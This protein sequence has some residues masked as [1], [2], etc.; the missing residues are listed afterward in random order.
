[1][2]SIE[3]R[4]SPRVLLARLLPAL[5]VASL[6][7]TALAD[8][9]RLKTEVAYPNLKFDRPVAMDYPDDGSDLLFVVEQFKATIQSFPDE[10][11]TT[12]QREFLKLPDPI[13]TENEEGLLGLAFHPKYK[14]NGEFFVY[15]S[16]HDM[17]NGRH[18]RRAVVSRVNVSKDD[19]RK[20]DPASEKRIWVSADDPAWNHNGG[21]I[22]FGPDGFLYIS[23][24]DGGAADDTIFTTGQNPKDWFGSILR[25]DVDHP[26]DGKAYG[27]P[28]DNPRLRDSKFAD[29]APEVYCIGLRNVWKFTFDRKDGTLW[30][31]D[32]GQNKWEMVHIIQNGGNYGWSVKESFHNFNTR[33][34][35]N[36]SSPITKPIVEYPHA[37]DR[38]YNPDRK[39]VGQSITGG[40]VYRGKA[41]PLDGVYI[42][43]DFQSGRIWGVRAKDGQAVENGELIDVSRQR[44]LNIAAFGENHEGDILILA[45]D[46]K[47][48][49]LV[50]AGN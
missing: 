50:P 35:V 25:I 4:L 37:I 21:C 16:A 31:G 20:A 10:R 6:G 9:P 27:I 1:M 48:H 38:N 5:L 46:G 7:S 49:H 44:V 30:A 24:G 42:Y 39:D 8:L 33:R 13:N 18:H 45:F 12:D 23:L 47:I 17:V 34:K 11:D 3:A 36:P 32:V 14:Q 29:W 15:Y 28:S 19:S 43:G 22:A 40:Y 26:S 2:P 41:L